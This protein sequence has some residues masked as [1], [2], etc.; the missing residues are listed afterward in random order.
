M[1]CRDTAHGR[2]LRSVSSRALKKIRKIRRCE[3]RTFCK[4]AIDSMDQPITQR[5]IPRMS[6]AVPKAG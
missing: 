5:M 4:S 2:G 6:L 3:R 1:L